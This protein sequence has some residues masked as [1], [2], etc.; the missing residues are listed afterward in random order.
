MHL[1]LGPRTLEKSVRWRIHQNP[2]PIT[3][4]SVVFSELPLQSVNVQG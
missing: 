3:G 1:R 2:I 4:K